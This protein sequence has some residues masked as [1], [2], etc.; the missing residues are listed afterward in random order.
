MRILTC[1]LGLILTPCYASAEAV[2]TGEIKSMGT[3]FTVTVRSA[4]PHQVESDIRNAAAILN[5]LDHRL[6]EWKADSPITSLNR[7]AGSG[8]PVSLPTDVYA[9]IATAQTL[10]AAT[11]GA[12]DITW[13][14]LWAEWRLDEKWVPPDPKQVQRKAS[15]VDYRKLRLYPE[16][17]SAALTLPDMAVGLGAIG[18]GYALDVLQEYFRRSGYSAFLLNAGGQV[19]AAGEKSPGVPWS[20][21]IQAPRG[22]RGELVTNVKLRDESISTSGDYEKFMIRGGKRFHHILDP[23]S[24]YPAT[25]SQS[26]TVVMV[27]PTLADAYSTACFVLGREQCLVLAHQQGFDVFFIDDQGDVTRSGRFED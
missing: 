24:G 20:I 6:S 14:A 15:L 23:R 10:S 27:D 9:L 5:A 17:R 19:Y 25:R 26:A 3:V 13:A 4:N 2:V 12:F 11:S 1:L 16:S 22:K 18:K 21:G 7:R 8:V